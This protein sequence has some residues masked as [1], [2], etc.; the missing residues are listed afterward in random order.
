MQVI[1]LQK[2]RNLGD[3]GDQ[4]HVRAGYG[5]NYLVPQGIALPA[6]E[7][8]VRVFEERKTE[9]LA[10]SKDREARARA[11]AEALQDGSFTLPMRAS[12]EGKLYGSVG[13]HE[14]AAKIAEEGHELDASEVILAEGAIRQVGRYPATLALHAE[15]QIEI[16]VVVAQLTDTG[17]NMPPET[18]AVEEVAEASPEE[19]EASESGDDMPSESEGAGEADEQAR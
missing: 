2:V 19:A 1:L 5:R 16:E 12:D 13:P 18:A 4:V 3:I 10:A 6:T 7:E 15:V 17:V 8:N 9:L 14:I 11:R